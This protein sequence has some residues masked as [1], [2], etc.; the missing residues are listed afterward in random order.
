MTTVCLTF[1]SAECSLDVTSWWFFLNICYVSEAWG[2]TTAAQWYVA[3]S[4]GCVRVLRV[5]K[6]EALEFF[7]VQVGYKILI[8]GGQLWGVACEKAIKVLRVTP[9]LPWRGEGRE[10]EGEDGVSLMRD[11]KKKMRTTNN[12][13]KKER[14]NWN[15]ASTNQITHSRNCGFPLV[16][17]WASDILASS[18]VTTLTNLNF[19]FVGVV[20]N[21]RWWLGLGN[22]R[23]NHFVNNLPSKFDYVISFLTVIEF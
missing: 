6:W 22:E 23:S 12:K 10:R 13:E 11:V 21:G 3:W 5:N 14:Y 19:A 9:T 7:L 15:M 1:H 4:V 16:H 2:I 18:L 8:W 20:T 17:K